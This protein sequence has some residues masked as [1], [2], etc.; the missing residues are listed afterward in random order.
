MI[1]FGVLKGKEIKNCSL[2]LPSLFLVSYL[3]VGLF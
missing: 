3:I 1:K 2:I